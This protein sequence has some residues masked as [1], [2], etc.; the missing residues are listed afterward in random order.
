MAAQQPT[1][2]QTIDAANKMINAHDALIASYNAYLATKE[3]Y[4][5]EVKAFN[6]TCSVPHCICLWC[7]KGLDCPISQLRADGMLV[8]PMNLHA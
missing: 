3:A 6:A 1:K 8:I 4:A 5:A 2:T 7:R